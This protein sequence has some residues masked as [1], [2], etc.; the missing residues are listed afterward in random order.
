M[1]VSAMSWAWD[2]KVMPKHQLILL[3]MSD[4]SDDKGVVNY[5]TDAMA[6]KVRM[7]VF[8]F[9]GH[10]KQLMAEGVIE[11]HPVDPHA[12]SGYVCHRLKVEA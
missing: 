8:E 12:P 10:L 2:Q 7:T 6:Q 9:T 5:Q 1:S 3:A 4:S 11:C